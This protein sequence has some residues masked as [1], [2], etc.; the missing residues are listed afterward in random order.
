MVFTRI[1]PDPQEPQKT[2]LKLPK[3]SQTNPQ[4]LP[5]VF[6]DGRLPRRKRWGMCVP[7]RGGSNASLEK[8]I[9]EHTFWVFSGRTFFQLRNLF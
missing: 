6:Q 3:P 1:F 7:V 5:N 8:Q 4:M 2:R 9:L